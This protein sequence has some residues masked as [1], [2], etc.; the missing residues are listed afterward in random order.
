M[1]A[2][3]LAGGWA[4]PG[5]DLIASVGEILA[6]RKI[7]VEVV[8][9]PM[10]AAQALDTR[11]D[12][13]VAGPCWFSM[14]DERYTPDQRSEFAVVLDEPLAQRLQ[15]LKAAG[16]PVLALHTA[17]ICFDSS[18][19][20]SDWLGGEWNW[21]TSWHPEPAL[22]QVRPATDSPIGF[23]EFSVT[24]ELYQGLDLASSVD[25]VAE[26]ATGD[27]L[28]WLHETSTARAAVNVLGHDARSLDTP[29]HRALIDQLLDRLLLDT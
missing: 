21:D 3:L 28:V 8:T 26:S 4:H 23:Q 16:C 14:T 10:L 6:R 25:V 29:A 7:D 2:V 1:H 27:P 22:I 19:T 15:D 18:P 24:D 11:C 9:D 20:W 12:L 5:D 13:L 17:V